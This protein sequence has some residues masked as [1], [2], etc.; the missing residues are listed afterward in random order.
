METGYAKLQLER[1][2][3]L[4]KNLY[5]S[6]AFDLK[7][8]EIHLRACGYPCRPV[9]LSKEEY[10]SEIKQEIGYVWWT[11]RIGPL[12][13]WEIAWE[14]QR[15][16]YRLTDC[17]GPGIRDQSGQEFYGIQIAPGFL[18]RATGD[19]LDA[20]WEEFPHHSVQLGWEKYGKPDD[21]KKFFVFDK[22]EKEELEGIGMANSEKRFRTR[23][24]KLSHSIEEIA[25]QIRTE[26][27]AYFRNGKQYLIGGMLFTFTDRDGMSLFT[28]GIFNLFVNGDRIGTFL[29]DV[30]DRGSEIVAVE[31]HRYLPLS[32]PKS[33][34]TYVANIRNQIG[35]GVCQC[36]SVGRSV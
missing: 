12:L 2:A 29:P 1:E 33:L 18:S 20:L 11:A 36:P 34:R 19:Q 7:N 5:F 21:F 13:P 8:A 26:G 35:S 3:P 25:R 28:N 9:P 17:H 27:M 24:G 22:Q 15:I 14:A 4:E 32:L 30:A 10:F 31:D 23:D 16:L 6:S